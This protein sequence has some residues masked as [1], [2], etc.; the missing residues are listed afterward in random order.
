MAG[1]VQ[2]S[3]SPG[4]WSVT[5]VAS[6]SSDRPGVLGIGRVKRYMYVYTKVHYIHP[7]LSCLS[8]AAFW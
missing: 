2:A 3:D 5:K 6:V 7:T 8:A 1:L 4:L